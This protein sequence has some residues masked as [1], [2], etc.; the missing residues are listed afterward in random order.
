VCVENQDGWALR[1]LA[2][3]RRNSSPLVK[4]WQ[5]WMPQANTLIHGNDSL[6][7]FPILPS[8]F[9]IPPH[10]R[11][12][13]ETGKLH[14]RGSHLPLTTMGAAVVCSIGEGDVR[15]GSCTVGSGIDGSD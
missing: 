9:F 15:V 2:I 5:P 3:A 11:K 4:L 8:L 10:P 14:A 1:D 12:S 6:F 7:G 13:S